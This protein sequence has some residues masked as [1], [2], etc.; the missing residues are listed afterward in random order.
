MPRRRRSYG[1][2]SPAKL[3]PKLVGMDAADS[4]PLERDEPITR[5]IW[6]LQIR[7]FKRQ[8]KLGRY[9]KCKEKNLI[10]IKTVRRSSVMPRRYMKIV[11]SLV[12]CVIV[13]VSQL[14]LI[15]GDR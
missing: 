7:F 6:F 13:E 12:C 11:A 5:S 1:S 4:D 8:S 14:I 9:L 2:L 10:I 15:S 3:S